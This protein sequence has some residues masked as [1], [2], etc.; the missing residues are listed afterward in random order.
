MIIQ[1]PKSKTKTMLKQK[2]K[3]LIE[4]HVEKPI[5]KKTNVQGEGEPKDATMDEDGLQPTLMG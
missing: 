4:E 5:K 3:M 1:C 2:G